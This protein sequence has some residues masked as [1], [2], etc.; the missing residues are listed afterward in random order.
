MAFIRRVLTIN[1]WEDSFMQNI[2]R[3]AAAILTIVAT[4]VA[5]V[6]RILLTPQMLDAETGEFQIS[7]VIIGILLVSIVAIFILA[8]AGKSPMPT[9]AELDKRTRGPIAYS[10]ML[11]G[12][13]LL[14]TSSVYL[15]NLIAT[16]ATPPPN[17]TVINGLDLTTLLLTLL[18]GILAGVFLIWLGIALVRGKMKQTTS[19]SVAALAPVVWI[20]MRLVRYEVSYASAIRVSESFYDFMML[21]FTMLFLFVFAR[22]IS[23]TGLRSPKMLLVYALCTVLLSLSGTI[24]K[25]VLYAMMENDAYQSCRLADLTDFGAGIFALF[26]VCSLVFVKPLPKVEQPAAPESAPAEEKS[27]IFDEPAEEPKPPEEPNE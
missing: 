26:V 6:M 15:L 16:R 25:L 22:Y 8:L 20:W 9:A 18:F 10:G 3:K 12:S 2:L 19:L 27:T 5:T 13:I 21:I 7:Y 11:F 1:Y 17:D 23:N 4:I 14:V 24:T